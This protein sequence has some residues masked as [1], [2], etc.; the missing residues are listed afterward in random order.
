MKLNSHQL[1]PI[2]F[3]RN[4]FGL[5]LFHSTGSGKT[6]TS[7]SMANQFTHDIIIITTKSSMKNFQDDIKKINFTKTI[8]FYT[9]KKFISKYETDI[10]ICHNMIVIIDEAHH[11]RNESREMLLIIN[12]V[13]NAYRLIL[14]TATPIINYPS[15]IS[16]LV[17]MV[18]Q[19]DILPTEKKLFDFY[20]IN[21][22]YKINNSDMLEKKLKNSISFYENKS[23]NDY[24]SS[25]EEIIRV[26]MSPEQMNKYKEFVG[27]IILD[28]KIINVD[29]DV[30]T[31]DLEINYNF[32]DKKKKNSFLSATRQL[33]NVVDK[34]TI[35]P[36]I[37]NVI[38][39]VIENPFP[40]IIYSNYLNA[41]VYPI[42]RELEKKDINYKIISGTLTQDKLKKYIDDYNSGK[43]KVLL[44]TSAGSESLD[45]KNTRQIHILEPHWNDSKIRQVI[46]RANRYQSHITLK[47]SEQ[48]IK[49]FRWISIFPLNIKYQTA[50]EYLEELSIKKD[51]IFIEFKNIIIKTSIENN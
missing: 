26:E 16:I 9:Y 12:A 49:I 11:L 29:T 47:K 22:E 15:D 45:L 2:Q 36:K 30:R 10:N 19:N 21:D 35:T 24:P 44:I 18:K 40:A 3:I 28:K 39:K 31:S 8:Y 43:I 17:N 13:Q 46:G 4:N 33:S 34:N 38:N 14:L 25:T 5:I 50:D 37:K 20:F 42:A 27:T 1:F 48:N 6:I 7:L 41:G 32:L 23:S 51:E